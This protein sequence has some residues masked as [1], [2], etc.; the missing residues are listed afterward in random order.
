M[1]DELE[2]RSAIYDKVFQS[3]GR[4]GKA[5]IIIISISYVVMLCAGCQI[6]I[7]VFAA[8]DV[9]FICK[10]N[11]TNETLISNT[12]Y[13][14]CSHNVYEHGISSS[15][16]EFSLD[17]GPKSHY[18]YFIHSSYWLGYLISNVIAGYL[19]DK[20]GRK[21]TCVI[22]LGVYSMNN[23]VYCGFATNCLARSLSAHIAI[24]PVANPTI[25]PLARHFV[26]HRLCSL[27]AHITSRLYYC[28]TSSRELDRF[29]PVT[30]IIAQLY[31]ASP[32]SPQCKRTKACK[33]KSTFIT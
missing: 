11:F 12:C 23:I 19:G 28:S 6:I 16:Q 13:K 5:Q 20:T 29:A 21:P 3:A 26:P 2:N 33:N 10:V 7:P 9:N 24:Q 25:Y 31:Q 1:V 22:S 15:T 30:Y 32:F 8:R 18:R 17:C 27:S 14:E 4:M